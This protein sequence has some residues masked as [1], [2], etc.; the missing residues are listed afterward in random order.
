MTF[1]PRGSGRSPIRLV[2]LL[3]DLEFGG[4]QRHLLELAHRLDPARFQAEVW[5][6]IARDDMVPLAR[7][8][9]IPLV[10]L[11]RGR[12]VGPVSIINLWRRL[13]TTRVDLLLA[14]TVVPNIWARILGRLRRVPLIVGNC[15][16]NTDPEEQCERWLWP[17]AHHIICNTGALKDGLTR[18]YGLP[19]NRLT[20]IH[21]GVDTEYF[22][23]PAAVPGNG[24]PPVVLC[25]ARMVRDKDHDTLIRAFQLVV[26]S[27]PQ[28]ELWL[29]G[30]GPRKAAVRR[31]A[32]VSLPPGRVRFI[33]GQ[34]DVRPFLH[35][36]SLLVL[37]SRSEGL[38]NVVLEAMASGLPVVSTDVGGLPEVVVPGET[39]WLTPPGDSAAL[40]AA[41]SHLLNDPETR[42]AFGRAG[43]RRVEQAFSLAAMVN[44]HQR[45]LERL[46][47]RI[48]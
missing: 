32:L 3:Q 48:V 18:G 27:H 41:I 15:R 43:R 25:I 20:V 17:L 42:L 8:R 23:P 45:V 19:E 24:D 7:A 11:S 6:L 46:A 38:P 35:R 5:L 36:A 22:R 40:A 16:S 28:A 33:P 21:N 9:S 39:G 44:H 2:L 30:D 26:Q 13:R 31:R 37:S 14:L 47:A 12:N 34:L 10:W 1:Q 29:V 4:T